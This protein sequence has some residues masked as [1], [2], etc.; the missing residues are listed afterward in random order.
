MST[1]KEKFIEI[2][3]HFRQLSDEMSK[4][5]QSFF[6]W[7]TLYLSRSIEEA[8]QKIAERNVEII[9][10]YKNFFIQ[11]EDNHLHSFVI[12]VSKFFDKDARALSIQFLINKIK[13]S[14]E[15]FTRE[16]IIEAYPERFNT[17]DMHSC[18]PIENE[19]EQ[20]IKEIKEKYQPLIDKL[21][22]FRDTRSAH[23][24]VKITDLTFI[25]TDVEGLINAIQEILNII[26]AR[27][28]DS[29]T[30]WRMLKEG[31]IRETNLLLENLDRGEKQRIKE[32]KEE[33]G[34]KD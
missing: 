5:V 17:V 10:S 34:I 26:S 1:N 30:D 29:T 23:H 3:G 12:G 33:Y 24:D 19:D 13:D 11:T 20:K 28:N 22:D 15:I 16:T 25:P 8:G 18:A 31:A 27:F 32:L 9:N 2:L 6:I 7:R 4:T 14:A 21:K